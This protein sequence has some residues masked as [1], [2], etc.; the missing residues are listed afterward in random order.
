MSVSV[1][2]MERRLATATKRLT[3]TEAAAVTGL[4][5]DEAEA[6]LRALLTRYDC[7]LQVTE[8]GDIIYDFGPR[9]HRRDE[10]SL[11]EYLDDALKLLWKGFVLCFKAW[12]AITLVVY[13]LIFLVILVMMIVAV[14]SDG[15]NSRRR[16]SS[17]GRFPLALFRLFL[18]IFEWNT[19]RQAKTYRT[20]RQG[21][22]YAAYQPQPALLQDKKD[23][24]NFIASVYDFVFGPPR[25]ERDPLENQK[26]VAAYLRR[27]KG[28][29]MVSEIKALTGM[30]STPAA[31]FF[32]DCIGRFQGD[33]RIS[34][35]KLM[36]GQF[37]RLLRTAGEQ[38]EDRIQYYWD[39][40][41]PPYLLTGNTPNMNGLIIFLNGFNL[42]FSLI[43]LAGGQDEFLTTW[44]GIVP[45]TF[46]LIFF[47][48]PLLRLP[49]VIA[50]N[51][52]RNAE[53]RRKRVMK[54][55]FA[56]RGRPQTADQVLRLVNEPGSPEPLSKATVENILAQ[57]V[58]D[59]PG[60]IRTDDRGEVWYE[61]P[62]ITLELEEATR[63]RAQ[64]VVDRDLGKV[65][66]DS[67]Q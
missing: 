60:D 16:R 62:V 27:N 64:R 2:V 12:I 3:L 57:L 7:I 5:V 55:I 52:R 51:I 14:L 17:A 6:A 54:A 61:F 30:N 8:N 9:L 1:E 43:M 21:Y 63:L 58:R 67:R 39:E 28:I 34:D 15:K 4:S 35:R 11:R 24:K 26:E 50:S 23:A 36:Y 45:F 13:F 33:I 44:L 38:T 10:K 66:F 25:V 56:N 31:L 53:N 41:E 59:L 19:A 20:D 18:A 65:V 29:L 47:A 22:R 48:V 37:D 40:Y 42:V 46:S 49:G 32:S